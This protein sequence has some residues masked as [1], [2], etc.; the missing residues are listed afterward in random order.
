[1]FSSLQYS[2]WFKLIRIIAFVEKLMVFIVYFKFMLKY[3]YMSLL[4]N[5]AF[6]ISNVGKLPF[7]PYSVFIVN[8]EKILP[9]VSVSL[10]LTLS[11][12]LLPILHHG[13]KS[14]KMISSTFLNFLKYTLFSGIFRFLSKIY[15]GAFCEIISILDVW[16]VSK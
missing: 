14:L 10:R 7:V 9:I 16:Q 8:F 12:F 2:L 6:K 3:R 1:M 4:I 15:D 13:L 5:Y 11:M